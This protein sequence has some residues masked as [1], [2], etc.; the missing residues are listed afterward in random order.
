MSITIVA[1]QEALAGLP[2]ERTRTVAAIA[3][4]R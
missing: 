2:S 4:G 1:V 3:D